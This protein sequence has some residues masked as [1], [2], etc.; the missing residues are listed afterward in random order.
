MALCAVSSSVLFSFFSPFAKSTGIPIVMIGVAS[1]VFGFSRFIFYYLT[2]K[3]RIRY[4][5]YHHGNRIRNVIVSI[6]VLSLSSLLITLPHQSS[7]GIYLISFA[8]AG[9][10]Y[11]IVY[12]ISQV[13]MLAE[14]SPERM[15]TSAGLFESSIGVGGAAGPVIA[16][17]IS[18][19]NLSN[20]FLAPSICLLPVLLM[21]FFILKHDKGNSMKVP[22]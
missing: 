2:I 11:S 5:L 19:N 16:G 4:F 3:K 20:S 8:I 9:A 12:S 18:G 13:A 1:F 17:V 21:Q 15:G 10:G 14:A 22:A 7:T 6:S